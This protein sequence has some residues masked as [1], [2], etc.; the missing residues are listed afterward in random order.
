MADHGTRP[1]GDH[2]QHVWTVDT[3]RVKPGRE[4]HFL[5]HC[6]AL[7]PEPLTLYRDAEEPGLF[8][9][10]AKWE[11]RQTLDRWRAGPEYLAAVRS[12]EVDV[13]DHQTHVMTDVPG[14]PPLASSSEDS[15]GL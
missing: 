12:L 14:F 11:S 6:R 3:W 7:T 2:G 13:L 4:A 10:P 1:R 15:R 9:S 8:W 5:D